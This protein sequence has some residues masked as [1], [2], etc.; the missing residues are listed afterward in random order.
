MRRFDEKVVIVTGSDSGIG[1]NI[2]LGFAK[3]GASIVVHGIDDELIDETVDLLKNAKVDESKILKIK[4]FF[5]DDFVLKK[6][7][8]ETI[9][10]FGRL[11]ILVNNAGVFK[12]PRTDHFKE[13]YSNENIDFVF[14]INT[15]A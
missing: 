15:R 3:E 7:I 12:K 10:K 1:Q 4:G 5:D 6:L 14:K 9:A 13:S 8:E 11:D 2:L